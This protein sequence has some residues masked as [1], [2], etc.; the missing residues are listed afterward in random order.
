MVKLPTEKELISAGVHF[1]HDSGKVYPKM[2]PYLQRK[3]SGIINLINLKETIESLKKV[4]DFINKSVK[5]EDIILFVGTK[6][7]AK[8]IV[9]KYA[10]EINMPYVN[11]HWIGGMLTNFSTILKLIE[12][13]K[14]M[15]K[16]KEE[17]EWEKYP[18]KEKIEL[19]E[20]F[21]KLEKNVGGIK[22]LNRLPDYLYIIDTIEEKTAVREANRLN[23]PIIAIVDVNGNPDLIDYP[24]P[25]NDDGIK[26]IDI[27]TKTIVEAI[28]EKQK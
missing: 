22:N 4:V 14:K 3:K 19:E 27:I 13:Y 1:G 28:K 15:K 17:G 24:I 25:A 21:E 9:E 2:R 10:K 7:V 18:K 8:K 23:I 11:E 5:K 20:E 6:P 12:K 16:E 26:S